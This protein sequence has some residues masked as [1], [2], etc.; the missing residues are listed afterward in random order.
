MTWFFHEKKNRRFKNRENMWWAWPKSAPKW[1][2]VMCWFNFRKEIFFSLDFCLLVIT[3]TWFPWR[4][5]VSERMSC[6][7]SAIFFANLSYNS[8]YINENI[9]QQKLAQKCQRTYFNWSDRYNTTYHPMLLP[10]FLSCNWINKFLV[11][12]FLR[13]F[14]LSIGGQWVKN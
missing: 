3:G 4:S 9:T 8:P 13:P 2:K 1:N 7:E 10:H 11:Q 14:R 5:R 12:S 6:E